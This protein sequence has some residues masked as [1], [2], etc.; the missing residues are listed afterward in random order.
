M[1]GV[2][3]ETTRAVAARLRRATSTIRGAAESG[4]LHGHQGMRDGRPVRGS[5]WSFAPAA[6]DAW[7]Q[8]LD[9]RAQ[10]EVCGCARHLRAVRRTA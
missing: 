9:I 3:W 8:G 10:T 6:V 2:P 1:T 7:V 4:V 5:R